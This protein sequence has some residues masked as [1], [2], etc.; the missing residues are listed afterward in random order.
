MIFLE[1]GKRKKQPK[2]FTAKPSVEVVPGP[3]KQAQKRSKSQ[4]R[5][6]R[7]WQWKEQKSKQFISLPME[8]LLSCFS[9]LLPNHSLPPLRGA[10]LTPI[11]KSWHLLFRNFI[12]YLWA[13]RI[14][15]SSFWKWFLVSCRLLSLPSTKDT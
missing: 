7:R 2:K 10:M 5:R 9:S 13:I 3:S 15:L 8:L 4:A 6:Q 1:G 11:H 14:S 12:F